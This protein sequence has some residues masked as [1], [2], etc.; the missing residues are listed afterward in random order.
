MDHSAGFEF[1]R[2]HCISLN[3]SVIPSNQE[4]NLSF[5]RYRVRILD[6]EENEVTNISSTS[7]FYI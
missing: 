3:E 2:L 5:T 4:A 6:F 7:N 1:C